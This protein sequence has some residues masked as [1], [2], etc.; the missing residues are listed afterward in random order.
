[1]II[2]KIIK[3]H[4]LTIYAYDGIIP[5]RRIF[6]SDAVRVIAGIAKGIKLEKLNGKE[7]RP[8]S[9]R[10]KEA[11]FSV[12]QFSI[13]G[14]KF[15]D[16][17]SGTGQMGIE[18]LSRKA[19]KSVFIDSRNEPIEIIKRNL[20]LTNLYDNANVL[21]MD[22]QTFL[23]K[24]N[25]TFD[26]AFLDPPYYSGEIQKAFPILTRV[27]NEDGIIICENPVDEELPQFIEN[28]TLHR[29]YRYGKIKVSIYRY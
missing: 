3:K 10:V 1:M 17:F 8:T 5:I 7:V 25:E 26:I 28:F 14:Q 4:L 23:S 18:A 13:E 22:A 9:D 6:R 24:T 20:R 11:I 2:L 12:I 16:L 21:N 19:S 27:M 29:I 15:L